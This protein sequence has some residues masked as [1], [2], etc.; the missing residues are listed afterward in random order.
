M[1]KALKRKRERES[2]R[3]REKGSEELKRAL[4]SGQAKK[5]Q[6]TGE[7]SHKMEEGQRYQLLQ[8]VVKQNCS[9]CAKIRDTIRRDNLVQGQ[10]TMLN[11]MA[12]D[13]GPL[14]LRPLADHRLE[15]VDLCSVSR[16]KRD[17][18]E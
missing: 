8:M 18:G 4:A 10:G 13:I 6:K 7:E 2:G 5:E 12:E 15:A 9:S 14:L 11:E 16:P 3:D 1:E 17:V